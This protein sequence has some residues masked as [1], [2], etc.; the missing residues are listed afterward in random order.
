MK[1]YVS[2]LFL[3]S[4]ASFIHASAPYPQMSSPPGDNNYYIHETKRYRII[5]DQQY[6]ND[7]DL[8]NQKTAHYLSELQRSQKI[9]LKGPVNVILLSAKNQ[10]SNALASLFPFTQINIFPSGLESGF[11]PWLDFAL[12]HELNHI[13]QM[14]HSYIAPLFLNRASKLPLLLFFLAPYPNINLPSLF[15][16]GEAVLK[17]SMFQIGGRL[18]KGFT[19][20]FVYTQINKYRNRIPELTKILINTMLHPHSKASHY[21][22]G[23]YLFSALEKRFSQK[24]INEF[25]KRNAV[26]NTLLSITFN[27]ALMDAFNMDIYELTHF[28][29]QHYARQ[30]YLQRSSSRPALLTSAVCEPFNKSE[31]KIFF[32][33][34]DHRSPPFLRIYDSRL[35]KWIHR[36]VD[37]PLG[38]IFKIGKKYYSRASTSIQP[39][40]QFYSLFSEGIYPH[41]SF[42]SKYVHD[43]RQGRILHT[44]SRNTLLQYKLYLDNQFY[45]DIH[46]NALFDSQNNVYYFKQ[47]RDIRILYKN[48]RPLFSYQGYDGTLVDIDRKGGIFFTAP[49][50]YG[51]S[52]YRYFR[53]RVTRSS[54]SDT[55]V[56][57]KQISDEEMLVCEVSPEG[58]D[59]KIVP[60]ESKNETPAVYQYHFQKTSPFKP[61]LSQTVNETTTGPE[62]AEEE[63]EESEQ[64][65]EQDP[66]LAEEFQ[67]TPKII[68]RSQQEDRFLNSMTRVED[69]TLPALEY[70]KYHALSKM[71][72]SNWTLLSTNLL[73]ALS[74]NPWNMSFRS[75]ILFTDFLQ[76]NY[77]DFSYEVHSILF[78]RAILVYENLIYPLYWNI[79]YAVGFLTLD[80]NNLERIFPY[81]IHTGHLTLAYP[82]F[83][84][85]RWF[86]TLRS[87]QSV[88]YG[89][90]DKNHKFLLTLKKQS[91][92]ECKSASCG[93]TKLRWIGNWTTGYTQKY[94]FA[95]SWQ[96]GLIFDLSMQYDYTPEFSKHDLSF[97]GNVHSASHLGYEFYLFPKISY[98]TALTEDTYPSR[99]SVFPGKKNY[100]AFSAKNNVGDLL[101]DLYPFQFYKSKMFF[102]AVS[103]LTA[104]LRFKKA[105]HTPLYFANFPVSIVRTIPFAETQYTFLKRPRKAL[106]A[107]IDWSLGKLRSSLEFIE[108]SIGLEMEFLFYYQKTII[109]SI[110]THGTSVPVQWL[111]AGYPLMG[112]SLHFFIKAPL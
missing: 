73:T 38:K 97:E 95:H 34:S 47:E 81:N 77:I 52:I 108:W 13:Y 91:K 12:I 14:S 49:T 5:F 100:S 43:M 71:R 9:D 84:K 102:D 103:S 29:V 19:R 45:D 82:L 35:K 83:K 94:P 85:G 23:A 111:P 69:L 110:F 109:F 70:Q 68:S 16:E 24:K 10:K 76:K 98:T 67:N 53:G 40:I 28:Y 15:V 72:F 74:L 101:I 58:Y 96:K 86:S 61:H 79:G 80:Y 3:I 51:S 37:L 63:E 99:S 36:R 75:S 59:Y 46:S 20:A 60:I 104:S 8:I 89:D 33:T 57:G 64:T 4:F 92:I 93:L 107:D 112:P 17:E 41:P 39:F 6:L 78:H 66:S 106:K 50:H 7:I 42:Y 65:E 2:L 55:I 31:Q 54:S 62:E 56:Y 48:K 32:L 90:Y 11:H 18:F 27:H 30:A 21:N 1:Y 25:F 87:T 44:D 105:F 88:L 26:R 22:H